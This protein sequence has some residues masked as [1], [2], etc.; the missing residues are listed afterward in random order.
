M[1]SIPFSYIIYSFIDL[2]I[3]TNVLSTCK[4]F[5]EAHP[6][7]LNLTFCVH[8]WQFWHRVFISC[9]LF[10]P[11][12]LFGVML[13]CL[14]EQFQVYLWTFSV[15]LFIYIYIYSSP[16]TLPTPALVSHCITFTTLLLLLVA[17]RSLKIVEI[18]YRVLCK[19]NSLT[20]MFGARL[21]V[22]P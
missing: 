6:T 17:L 3:T 4:T 19:G 8:L 10:V 5:G 16:K 13:R 9:I 1:L 14:F 20:F 22:K 12:W 2:F 11:L 18:L 7:F 21:A 15:C